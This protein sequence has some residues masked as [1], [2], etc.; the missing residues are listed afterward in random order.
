MKAY[1][2]WTNKEKNEL[3]AG[4][5]P[6]GRT[7]RAC[8]MFCRRQGIPFPTFAEVVRDENGAVLCETCKR[9]SRCDHDKKHC[10][11]TGDTK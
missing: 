11:G 5:I 2:L 8:I 10:K 4:R 7:R 6:R 9:F 1:R 3:L